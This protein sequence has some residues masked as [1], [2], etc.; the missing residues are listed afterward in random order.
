MHAY[1]R[2]NVLSGALQPGS[3]FSRTFIDTNKDATNTN[4]PN[5]LDVQD[6]QKFMV[7]STFF[8]ITLNK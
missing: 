1:E 3:K 7:E 6:W 2:L 8:Q 5:P 4:K